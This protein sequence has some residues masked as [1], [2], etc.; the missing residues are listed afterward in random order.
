MCCVVYVY[1]SSS[2]SNLI[3]N[4]VKPNVLIGGGYDGRL[5]KCLIR[6]VFFNRNYPFHASKL[7]EKEAHNEMVIGLA[8][9][10]R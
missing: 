7:S 8:E 2:Y 9:A 4:F 5:V 10:L 6:L 1:V 3:N